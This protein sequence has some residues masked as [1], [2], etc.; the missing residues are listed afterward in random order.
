MWCGPNLQY[1]PEGE[2]CPD[3]PPLPTLHTPAVTNPGC[4]SE[5]GVHYQEGE[6]WQ[7]DT[8]T[9]CTCQAGLPLCTSIQCEVPENCEQLILTPGQCCPTCASVSAP[10]PLIVSAPQCEEDGQAHEERESWTR[11]GDP[12]TTCFCIGGEILC[13]SES[14]YVEC[15]NPLYL[16]DTCCPI[17]PSKYTLPLP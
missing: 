17:C 11:N 10:T 9:T 1:V 3:C 16:L 8:C 6:S 14:C 13:A 12:C 5:E 4:Q 2:C 7:R 15:E